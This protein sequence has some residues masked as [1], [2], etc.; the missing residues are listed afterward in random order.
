[1][2]YTAF[3]VL[4]KYMPKA[5]R[6]SH[7][8]VWYISHLKLIL[9]IKNRA[10][11]DNSWANPDNSVPPH[12]IYTSLQITQIQCCHGGY[13]Q[14]PQISTRVS[15]EPYGSTMYIFNICHGVF[16]QLLVPVFLSLYMNPAA[17]VVTGHLCPILVIRYCCVTIGYF[18]SYTK[19]TSV[20][21]KK[22]KNK[23]QFK[24]FPQRLFKYQHF[25]QS[26]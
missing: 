20:L 18:Q 7:D 8:S 11:W 4:V 6:F 25:N 2:T 9:A 13:V 16:H 24:K 17:T 19:F 15:Q 5:D 10:R 26:R 12:I 23:E 14:L 1:M 3:T 22:I 21:A